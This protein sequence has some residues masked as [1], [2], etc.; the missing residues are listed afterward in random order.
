MRAND[1]TEVSSIPAESRQRELER[2]GA[3]LYTESD[4]DWQEEEADGQPETIRER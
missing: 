3:N 4:A 2:G 1:P